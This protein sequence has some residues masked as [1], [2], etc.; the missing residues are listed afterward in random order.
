MVSLDTDRGSTAGAEE[1][2]KTIFKD[3]RFK[4]LLEKKDE[5]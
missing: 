3:R 4:Y 2:E 5:K 1:Q